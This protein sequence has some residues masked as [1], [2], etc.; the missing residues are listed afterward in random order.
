[1]KVTVGNTSIL[2]SIDNSSDLLSWASHR[3]KHTCIC[4]EGDLGG[5]MHFTKWL[6]MTCENR[7]KGNDLTLLQ[8]VKTPLRPSHLPYS[9][10]TST[11]LWSHCWNLKKKRSC[12][13]GQEGAPIINLLK[14]AASVYCRRHKMAKTRNGLIIVWGVNDHDDFFVGR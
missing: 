11:K 9:M 10:S 14:R 1:M 6:G 8:E 7:L 5:L 4:R 12:S 2:R 13:E 3:R